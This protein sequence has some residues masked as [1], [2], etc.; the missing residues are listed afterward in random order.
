MLFA[1]AIGAVV[2]QVPYKHK[3]TS[4]NLVSPTR[5][6]EVGGIPSDF[7]Y[8]ELVDLYFWSLFSRLR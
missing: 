5:K 2:A 3:V 1:R 8:C 6:H 7:F 4:S